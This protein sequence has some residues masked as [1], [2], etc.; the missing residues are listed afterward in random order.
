MKDYIAE[1]INRY[2]ED[3]NNDNF[4]YVYTRAASHFSLVTDIG[5]LTNIFEAADIHP[6]D[7]MKIV[8]MYYFAGSDK[9]KLEIT[10]PSV[11]ALYSKCICFCNNLKTIAI[12]HSVKMISTDA[13]NDCPNLQYIRYDGT[14]DDFFEINCNRKLLR[15][16]FPKLEVLCL[17][18][19]EVYPKYEI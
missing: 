8:P 5:E 15:E 6:L 12:P 2:E 10:S 19:G 1:F 18:D 16:L 17:R 4:L 13:F 9:E 14:L 11:K 3:I 7:H